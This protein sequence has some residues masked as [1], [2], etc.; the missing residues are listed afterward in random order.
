MAQDNNAANL[1]LAQIL[2]TLANLPPMPEVTQQSQPQFYNPTQ[3]YYPTSASKHETN[4]PPPGPYQS[5]PSLDPTSNNWS[6]LQHRQAPPKPQQCRN[7]T[8]TIDPSTIVE[9]KHGL[10]CVNK[11]AAQ[12]SNFAASVQKVRLQNTPGLCPSY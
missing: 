12:N 3:G 8:P 7:A 4:T 6:S 11:V 10:R 1:D 2:Q 9:W 5:S